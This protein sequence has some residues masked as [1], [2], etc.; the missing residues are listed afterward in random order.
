MRGLCRVKI[1]HINIIYEEMIL[2]KTKDLIIM[3]T[4]KILARLRDD[5]KMAGCI[6]YRE[7]QKSGSIKVVEEVII[8]GMTPDEVTAS[9]DHNYKLEA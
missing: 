3:K 4:G 9:W 8:T 7:L 6:S 2:Q 1:K 5:G